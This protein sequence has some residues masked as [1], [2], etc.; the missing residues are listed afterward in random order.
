MQIY[1]FENGFGAEISDID[2]HQSC[3]SDPS[4]VRALEGALLKYQVLKIIDQDLNPVSLT[5]ISSKFGKFAEVPFVEC[6][7]DTG[8][9]I[10]VKR[11][12]SETTPI[13]GSHWHSDWSFLEKP[14]KF[15]FLYGHVVPPTGG[16]TIFADCVRGYESLPC[17]LKEKITQGYAI[18]SAARAYGPFGLFA[19]DDCTRSMKIKISAEA[20]KKVIHPIVRCVVESGKEAVFVN[21]VYTVGL[22]FREDSEAKLLLDRLFAHVTTEEF[23]LPISWSRGTLLVWDN[24]TVMHF[25]EGGYEGYERVMWRTT[26]GRDRPIRDTSFQ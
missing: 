2:L 8:N 5:L 16:R 10:E 12:R 14:P 15:S 17:S 20:E 11:S 19:K 1:P 9:V 25:A 26:V 22:K 23:R 7:S 21:P 24:R 3:L 13:F 4:M 18:H 6:L